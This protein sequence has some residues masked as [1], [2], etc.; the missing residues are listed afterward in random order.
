MLWEEYTRLHIDREPED[1]K[2]IES[3]SYDLEVT[4]K[5]ISNL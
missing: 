3:V 1:L 2:I 4:D 5:F